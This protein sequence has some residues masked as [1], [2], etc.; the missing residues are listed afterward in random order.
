M[1]STSSP[2]K[3][4][5]PLKK[6]AVV[7][8]DFD[9]AAVDFSRLTVDEQKLQASSPRSPLKLTKFKKASRSPASEIKV[10]KTLP[11]GLSLIEHHFV[12]KKDEYRPSMGMIFLERQGMVFVQSERRPDSGANVVYDK[13]NNAYYAVSAVLKI[14]DVDENLRQALLSEGHEEHYYHAPLKV[15]YIQ[16]THDK[17][18]TLYEEIRSRNLNADLEIIRAFNGPR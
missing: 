3:V 14:K 2:K 8:K 17:I 1:T 18:V 11:G 15:M 4:L 13:N 12:V 10:Y 9:K 6:I 7:K 5:A 16:S